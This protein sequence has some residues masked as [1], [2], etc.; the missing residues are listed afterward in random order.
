[1]ETIAVINR[2]GGIGKTTTAHALGAGLHRRGYSVLF[3][4]LDS[5][6]NLTF[7]TGAPR[8]HNCMEFLTGARDKADLIEHTESGDIVPAGDELATADL[9]LKSEYLLSSALKGLNYDY[10]IIDTPAALG[11]LN[12]NALTA[13]DSVIIPA[14]ADIYSLQGIGLLY[15]LINA[16]KASSNK[17]LKVKGFLL[18]QYN[19]RSTLSKDMKESLEEFAEKLGTRVFTSYIRKNDKVKEAQCMRKDIFSYAPKSNAAKDYDAFI[20]EFLQYGERK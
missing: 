20:N 17:R 12:A 3:I 1:M 9:V 6:G 5:Q 16:V 10:V 2:K 13:A 7:A 19:P 8:G 15:D 18:V 11:R 4:D 14:W